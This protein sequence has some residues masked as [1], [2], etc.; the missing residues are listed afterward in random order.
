MNTVFTL[1]NSIAF[2]VMTSAF[3][4]EFF[5]HHYISD[6]LETINPCGSG[7]YTAYDNASLYFLGVILFSLFCRMLYLIAQQ[8]S[9]T[10]NN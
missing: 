8:K 7:C 9:H 2:F 1:K 6:I 3:F 5:I 4:S 10:Q